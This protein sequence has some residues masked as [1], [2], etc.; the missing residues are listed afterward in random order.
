MRG[1]ARLLQ[2]LSVA[3]CFSILS[4]Q[5]AR[6]ICFSSAD[7]PAGL[8]CRAGFLGIPVCRE[9]ACNFDRDCPANQRPCAGLCVA[10]ARL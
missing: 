4:A 8:T 3:F 10:P 5:S 9:I 6:A 7:C 2:V 1:I